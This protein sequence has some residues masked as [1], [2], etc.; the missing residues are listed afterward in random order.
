M[1][2]ELELESKW[3]VPSTKKVPKTYSDRQLGTPTTTFSIQRCPVRL[4]LINFAKK[5]KL[6]I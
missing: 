1:C 6:L 5:S 3:R 2:L 4:I